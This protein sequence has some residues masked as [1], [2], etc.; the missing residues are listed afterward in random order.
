MNGMK[1]VRKG[2]NVSNSRAADVIIDSS[3]ES[4]PVHWEGEFSVFVSPIASQIYYTTTI[5]HNLGY[6]PRVMG[7]VDSSDDNGRPTRRKMYAQEGVWRYF[8]SADDQRVTI[9]AGWSDAQNPPS[10]APFKKTGYVYIFTG[11]MSKT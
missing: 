10:G 6:M 4:M 3:L 1:I 8:L 2:K 9:T 5:P 7:W 11:D